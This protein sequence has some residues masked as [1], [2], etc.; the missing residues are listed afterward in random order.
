MAFSAAI[1]TNRAMEST[2]M[3][4]T[5]PVLLPVPHARNL[6]R[7]APSQ[8][9]IRR[10]TLLCRIFFCSWNMPNISASLVGGHPGT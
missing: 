8:P 10:L 5:F 7:S 1:V 3:K 6:P 2:N 9:L 4:L